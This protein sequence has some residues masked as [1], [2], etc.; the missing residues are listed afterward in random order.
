MLEKILGTAARISLLRVLLTEKEREWSLNELAREAG[1]STSTVFKEAKN[2]VGTV[3]SH[4]PLTKRY[5][6]NETPFTQALRKLFML[7]K[8]GFEAADLFGTLG[9]LGSY[10]LSGSSAVV[11]RGLA[12]DFT[13]TADSLLIVCDRRISKLRG[14]LMKLFPAYRLL[15]VEESIRPADF[16]EGEIYFGGEV[17]RA[18]LAVLEKAVVDALWRFRWEG[19]NLGHALYC[20]VER[21]M[22]PELL[23][24]YAREKGRKVEGRLRMVMEIL[25]RVTGADYGLEAL[26]PG[27]EERELRRRVERAVEDVL[28]S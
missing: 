9:R 28:G 26:R 5:W 12:R 15:L 16:V 4:D 27:R 25:S 19:E 3:L 1:L 20:L 21:R 23:V 10:Y 11:L 8:E 13:T 17:R 18:N 22:D 7:E 14:A 6:V 2:L 24:K